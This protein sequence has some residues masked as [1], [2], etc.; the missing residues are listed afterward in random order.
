MLSSGGSRASTVVIRR[1]KGYM[2]ELQAP[3]LVRD[4]PRYM[5]CVTSSGCSATACC[6]H[7]K[8]EVLQDPVPGVA[9]HGVGKRVYCAP[10]RVNGQKPPKYCAFFET[11]MEQLLAV[12]A[13]NATSTEDCT[14][15]L[16][17]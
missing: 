9:G 6:F 1:I 10:V 13:A 16:P 2:A 12:D 15:A 7:T 4:Y 11:L 5:G 17:A 3:E 8:A 14:A